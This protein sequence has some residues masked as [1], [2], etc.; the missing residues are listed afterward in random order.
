MIPTKTFDGTVEGNLDG[1]S[2]EMDFDLSEEGRAHLISVMTDLYSDKELAPLREY[3]TNAYDS[4]VESGQPNRPI[5]VTTPTQMSPNLVIQ[6]FGIG[7][8]VEDM[9]QTFSKYGASS[10]RKSNDVQG[11]LGLGGKSALTYT[12]QFTITA[13]KDGVKA[14][15]IV[16]RD[17]NG[18]GVINVVSETRT[19]E[20]NG[21][22]IT[23][24][25][26][27]RNDFPAK[28]RQFFY[29]WKRGTVLLDGVEPDHLLDEKRV[30]KIGDRNFIK[31]GEWYGKD[32]VVM[33]NV[34]YELPDRRLSEKITQNYNNVVIHF[35]D[36]G[37]VSFAPSR[38]ALAFTGKTTAYLDQ[39]QADMR[40]EI[41]KAMTVE[42]DQAKS[43]GQ[44]FEIWSRWVNIIGGDKLPS[45]EYQGEKLRAIERVVHY[46][47]HIGNGRYSDATGTW[48]NR[49][50][51]GSQITLAGLNQP[52]VMVVT[53][54]TNMT[55]P[56]TSVSKRL[57]AY[58]TANNESPDLVYF[59]DKMPGKPWTDEITTV[60]FAD[61]AAMPLPKSVRALSGK[62][63]T[64][65]VI[66]YR[67]GGYSGYRRSSSSRG[68]WDDITVLD[69]TQ[70]ILY[71]STAMI[72]TYIDRIMKVQTAFPDKQIVGLGKNRWTKFLRE[73]PTAQEFL[74]Y[75]LNKF[76]K[77]LVAAMT[78]DDKFYA[79]H[80][81]S[82]RTMA[83]LV[84]NKT[85]DPTFE[86]LT[87]KVATGT[88]EIYN[89]GTR[90]TVTL[91]TKYPL[92]SNRYG[93]TGD[94]KVKHAIA[95]IN[96]VHNEGV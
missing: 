58:L 61:I 87:R 9:R 36:M 63:G 59:F 71:V 11:M 24:P 67:S 12:S 69:T 57:T 70:D 29:Y 78:E 28:A 13:I 46:M 34:A 19:H 83:A 6:D 74:T 56:S 18:I 31:S 94:V 55:K 64:I 20:A 43:H 49:I 23:I 42:L 45:M 82:Y 75:Y 8:S 66:I 25:A 92:L 79:K 32:I 73:N 54:Y 48:G 51:E 53:G 85:D 37:A 40:G 76:D 47:A 81:D 65:P 26:K 50:G 44:A 93:G 86:R 80:D 33:G 91:S 52:T 89:R 22:T 39:V 68:K 41:K 15:A 2:I 16:T 62:T 90:P 30:S 17:D 60:D 96:M 4:H 14:Q 10:K 72:T 95:Y 88:I 7:M 1:E 27:A 38:E 5:E 3:S 21:V 35:A 77:E 84:K